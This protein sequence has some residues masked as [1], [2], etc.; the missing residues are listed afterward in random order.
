MHLFTMGIII[1]FEMSSKLDNLM[2]IG[3]E[4]GEIFKAMKHL[5]IKRFYVSD[6]KKI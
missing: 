4:P 3:D 2:A 1:G 6:L 5:E